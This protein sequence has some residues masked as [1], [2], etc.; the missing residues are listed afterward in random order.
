VHFWGSWCP[1]CLR[2]LPALE[3][4]HEQI[5]TR[6]GGEIEMILLQ[7]RESFEEA[8]LWAEANGFTELPLYDS[9]STGSDDTDLP[10]AQGGEV[11]DRKIARVFPSSYVLDRR[12]VVVFSHF[13][14]IEDWLEYLPFFEHAARHAGA[15]DA[16]RSDKP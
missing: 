14:P 10:L 15:P 16:D 3:K 13:G 11:E 8:H 9:G 1:P 4:L 2:E 7:V 5:R 6:L 12:G